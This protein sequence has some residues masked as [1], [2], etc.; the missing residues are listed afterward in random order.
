[1]SLNF[2]ILIMVFHTYLAHLVSSSRKEKISSIIPS[3]KMVQIGR[4]FVNYNDLGT[5]E[6]LE[7]ARRRNN[8]A[9]IAFASLIVIFN[10]IFWSIALTERMKTPDSYL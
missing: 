5:E 3:S 6:C 10:I 9:K 8:V 2:L 4:G 7:M 1:M